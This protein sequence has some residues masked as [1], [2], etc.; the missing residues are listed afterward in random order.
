MEALTRL[1][2][3]LFLWV[4]PASA[5]PDRLA[6]GDVELGLSASVVSIEGSTAGEFTARGGRFFA[7]PGGL[8]G[9]EVG[10]GYA[11]LLDLDRLDLDLS[12]DWQPDLPDTAAHPY[13]G[14]R[15]G[16]RQEWLGSFQVARYPVGPVA[17]L[18]TLVAERALVRSEIRL[19]RVLD[20]PA[21]AYW[22]LGLSAGVSFLR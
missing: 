13:L 18:R 19:L 5:A 7:A 17:G 1:G 6:S 8:C 11:T 10:L 4:D 14:L 15:V 22:E 9:V 20:D 12:V 2:L 3:L 16:V 21:G